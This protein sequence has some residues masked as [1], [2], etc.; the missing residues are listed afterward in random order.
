MAAKDVF[1]D[2]VRHALEKDGWTITAES[3]SEQSDVMYS[4]AAAKES[5]RIAVDLTHFVSPA[6][7]PQLVQTILS[8]YA[9]KSHTGSDMEVQTVFDTKRH[10][11]Q[12]VNVGWRGQR[13]LYGSIIHIDIKSGKIWIQWD[14][15]EVG[16]ANELVERGVPKEDI[17]LAFQAPSKRKYTGFAV[18]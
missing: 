6:T 9:L 15:T 10:H 5:Q 18:G 1:H 17:V 13:R 16:L 8:D 2:T 11:Y 3:A 12:L 4:I 14:G 7:Y